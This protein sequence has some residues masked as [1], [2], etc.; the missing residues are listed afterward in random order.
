MA[1]WRWLIQVQTNTQKKKNKKKTKHTIWETKKDRQQVGWEGTNGSLIGGLLGYLLA[2]VRGRERG[3]L[4]GR[5]GDVRDLPL[6]LGLP[7]GVHLLEGLL[8]LVTLVLAQQALHLGLLLLLLLEEVGDGAVV[9]LHGVVLV[10]HGVVLLLLLVEL[11]NLLGQGLLLSPLQG[12]GGL[13]LV[14]SPRLL[15]LQRRELSRR[16]KPPARSS[17]PLH[18]MGVPRF[19]EVGLRRKAEVRPKKDRAENSEGWGGGL[20]FLAF[21][22]LFSFSSLALAAL[23]FRMRWYCLALTYRG[24]SSITSLWG[25]GTRGN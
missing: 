24:S 5:G 1:I 18:G 13:W 19:M 20:T 14:L 16:Q 8:R 7:L 10:L 23:R 21:S 12:R 17:G 4:G 6:H 15:L 2:R 11:L 25:M 22:S 9:A 3:G